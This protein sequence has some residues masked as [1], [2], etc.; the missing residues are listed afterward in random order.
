[1][2][3]KDNKGQGMNKKEV[4]LSLKSLKR[5]ASPECRSASVSEA[6]ETL[7]NVCEFLLDSNQP[8][9]SKREDN[10]KFREISDDEWDSFPSSDQIKPYD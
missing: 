6:I 9:R 4:L 3:R 2:L 10:L 8:E 1:M 7:I 5:E